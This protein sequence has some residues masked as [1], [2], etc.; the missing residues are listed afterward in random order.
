MIGEKHYL[1]ELGNVVTNQPVWPGDTLSHRTANV[2]GERGWIKRD[3]KG[4]WIA[5]R[6]GERTL[7]SHLKKILDQEGV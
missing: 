1:E 6:L 3:S 2:C 5:T 4:D 7:N